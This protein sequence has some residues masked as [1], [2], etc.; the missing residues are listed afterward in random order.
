MQG[1]SSVSA[2]GGYGALCVFILKSLC[3]LVVRT[4]FIVSITSV[5]T[6]T[7]LNQGG[8]LNPSIKCMPCSSLKN[9]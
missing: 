8:H 9:E 6:E 7:D 2:D 1:V 4:D 5:I 3:F